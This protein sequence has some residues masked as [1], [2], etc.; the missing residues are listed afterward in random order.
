MLRLVQL[1][2]HTDNVGGDATNQPLSENRANSVKNILVRY[3]V[4]ATG[5]QTRGYGSTQPK[6][7][8]NTDQGKFLNRRI[9]YSVVKK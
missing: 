6:F 2:G 3:G 9:Q 8:N 4:S 1:G 5:L 7:D